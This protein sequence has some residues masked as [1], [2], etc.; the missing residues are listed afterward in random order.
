MAN[1]SSYLPDGIDESNVA[2]TG[3]SING[4]TIG[5]STAAAGTFTTFTSNGIDDNADAV[6]ITIDSSENVGIGAAPNTTGFGGTFKYLGVNGGSGYGVFN[7]QTTSTTANDAAASFFGTTTGSSGYKLLGGMQVINSASSASNAEGAL[8]F[9]T[10]TGGSLAERMRID[11]S[12]NV[13]IGTTSPSEDLSIVGSVSTKAF[14]VNTPQGR[15]FEVLL[16]DAAGSTGPTLQTNTGAGFNIRSAASGFITLG[17]NAE[18]MRIDSSGKVGI[19]TASPASELEVSGAS[20]GQVSL[21]YTGNSGYASIKTDSASR[22]IFSTHLNNEQMRIDENGTV[23][24]GKTSTAID[25]TGTLMY[26]NGEIYSTTINSHFSYVSYDTTNDVYRFK[27][28]GAGQISATQTSISSI[29]DASLKE[30]VRDL[31]KGLDA[32]LDLQPRRFDWKNGDGNDVMGFVAQ[33]VEDVFPELVSDTEY[34]RGVNKKALKM[35]DMVPSMV[36]AI[37][38]QQAMIEELKAEVAALKGA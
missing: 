22:L 2:I 24:V 10:A 7:G 8:N 19:G 34:S 21:R 36:K 17:V 27:V 30:N 3:G 38:E 37:Q 9:F 31:D 15:G 12:G 14:S 18:H 35:G 11:S 25:S 4:T 26:G 32:I 20:G 13:G 29:S 23:I 16:G 1:L 6:A 28:S 33:E 5:A